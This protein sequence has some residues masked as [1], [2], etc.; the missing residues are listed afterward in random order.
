MLIE[1]FFLYSY[2]SIRILHIIVTF[3]LLL[4][5]CYGVNEQTSQIGDYYFMCRKGDAWSEICKQHSPNDI[6]DSIFL[7]GLTQVENHFLSP[8]YILYF[9]DSPR[10]IIGCDDYSVRVAFSPEICDYTVDGLSQELSDAEQ[11]RIRNRVLTLLKP[12]ECPEGQENFQKLLDAP[13]IFG[14]E[15]YNQR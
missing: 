11:I 6:K 14:E 15:Y 10:E 12:Y 2:M 4:T 5:S 9:D 13:A 7:D 3:P 8:K 1:Q